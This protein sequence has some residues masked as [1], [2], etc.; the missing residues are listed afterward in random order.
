M[1]FT[2]PN[3]CDYPKPKPLQAP[4][5]RIRL[6]GIKLNLCAASLYLNCSVL[7]PQF[8]SLR[9]MIRSQQD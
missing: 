5:S 3:S 2:K 7:E 8:I 4:K 9:D 1:K 6:C